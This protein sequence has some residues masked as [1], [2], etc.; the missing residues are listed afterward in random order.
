MEFYRD[1]FT[2]IEQR[3]STSWHHFSS[4]FARIF[5]SVF[6]R[7]RLFQWEASSF[8]H[9]YVFAV[10]RFFRPDVFIWENVFGESFSQASIRFL[11]TRCFYDIGGFSTWMATVFNTAWFLP[12]TE[13]IYLFV[14]RFWPYRRCIFLWRCGG[15]FRAGKTR[16][17]FH[18]CGTITFLL[19]TAQFFGN[20]LINLFATGNFL[21]TA[22]RRIELFELHADF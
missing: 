15:I 18:T 22:E 2:E 21:M 4:L 14:W 8:L 17:I 3:K 13:R 7:Q 20:Y 11:E 5:S 12:L 9:R 10:G 16:F 1:L 6:T 19:Q